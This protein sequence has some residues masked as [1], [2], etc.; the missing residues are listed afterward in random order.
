M[1]RGSDGSAQLP[2]A[3]FGSVGRVEGRVERSAR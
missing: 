3:K 2:P 1:E